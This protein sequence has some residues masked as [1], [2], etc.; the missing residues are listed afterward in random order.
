MIELD[1][2]QHFKQVSKWK[3]PEHNLFNDVNKVN[4]AYKN[5]KSIIHLLQEDVFSDKNDWENKL[6]QCIKQYEKI[7]C[8]FIDNNGIYKN[9]IDSI[10]KKIKKII[11]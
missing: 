8:V 1:G 2:L 6:T 7:S 4:L 5:K 10:H 3:S 9:H 11:V